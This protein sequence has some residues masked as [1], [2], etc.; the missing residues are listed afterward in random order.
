MMSA[1]RDAAVRTAAGRSPL[2]VQLRPALALSAEQFFALAQLNR[3]LRLEL[4]AQGALIVMSPTGGETSR[5]NVKIVFQLE[6]WAVRDG[7]GAVFDSSGGFILPNGA[8]RSPDASWVSNARLA[9]L[10][11]AQRERFPPLCPDVVIELRSPTDSLRALQEKMREYLDNGARLGWLLD[12]EEKRVYRY[13]PGVATEQLDAP[14]TLAGD[15]VLPG[16][17]LDLRA[18]WPLGEGL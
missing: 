11:T 15:P 1:I 17:V 5:R 6:S 14:E 8:T 9:P 13:R 7:T 4:T 2:A 18:V 10:T 12:P 16:F 3:E